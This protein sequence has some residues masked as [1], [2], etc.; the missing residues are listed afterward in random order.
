MLR[1]GAD[2]A[3]RGGGEPGGLR[4]SRAHPARPRYHGSLRTAQVGEPE[5]QR[6]RTQRCGRGRVKRGST[7]MRAVGRVILLP[8]AFILAAVA[9]LFVVFS[10]GQERVVQA[11]STRMQ[12][13]V[14]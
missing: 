10:L 4:E 7:M 9:A 8:I 12:N 6:A 3:L 13:D 1:L 2:R 14:P 11:I 5:A